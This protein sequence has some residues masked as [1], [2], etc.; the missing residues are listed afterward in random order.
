MLSA[1]AGMQPEDILSFWFAGDMRKRWFRST[2]AIDREIRMRFEELWRRATVGQLDDWASTPDGALA[3][4]I[5]LDQF[6][7]NMFRNR[8]KSFASEAKAIALSKAAVDQGL[9]QTLAQEQVAFL[10]MPLMHSEDLED[11]ERS[12][13]LFQAAGLDDNLRFARH[14]RD[15]IKRFGRFPHRNAILGRPSSQE[16]LD[17]LASK[18][19]FKG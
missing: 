7:L 16:E 17:Y 19:A 11:Q 8:P 6:P 1:E 18:G 4:A 3:L 12:V 2:E 9:D 10:Y 13:A 5:V 14:H 15:L